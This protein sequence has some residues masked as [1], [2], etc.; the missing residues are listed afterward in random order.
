M[1]VP[2]LHNRFPHYWFHGMHHAIPKLLDLPIWRRIHSG[3]AARMCI[4]GLAADYSLLGCWVATV[5]VAL[6]T[7]VFALERRSA[8][9]ERPTL[10]WRV[11]NLPFVRRR[12]S[13]LSPLCGS[14][15]S[16]GMTVLRGCLCPERDTLGASSARLQIAHREPR[17]SGCVGESVM[18]PFRE[19]WQ[20]LTCRWVAPP[21]SRAPPGLSIES[22]GSGCCQSK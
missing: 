6:V 13:R 18:I 3:R 15:S 21:R 7:V 12:T 22:G 11:V 8:D 14:M 19:S 5:T 1:R 9:N 4:F 20:A 16:L 2:P 17:D 10:G